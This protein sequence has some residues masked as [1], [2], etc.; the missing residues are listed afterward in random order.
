MLTRD[1]VCSFTV[2]KIARFQNRVR[3][4]NDLTVSHILYCRLG[5]LPAADQGVRLCLTRM[6]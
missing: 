1:S 4:L 3:V 6:F 5:R 2:Y